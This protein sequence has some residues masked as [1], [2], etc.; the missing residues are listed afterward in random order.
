MKSVLC[1]LALLAFCGTSTAQSSV[2]IYGVV[3]MSIARLSGDG[4]G[5]KTGVAS[6]SLGASRLGFSGTEDLGGGLSAN[7]I[8]ESALSLDDGQSAGVTFVRQST[9]GLIGPFGELRLGRDY[10][11]T[12]LNTSRFDPFA[13]RGVGIG[14]AYNNFFSDEVRNSNTVGYFLPPNMGGF[15]G[16]VQYAFGE[17]QSNVP[18]TKQRDYTGGRLGYLNGPLNLAGAWG[19]YK[20]IVGASDTAPVVIGKDLTNTNFGISWDF[21]FIKPSFL[22][23]QEKVSNGAVGAS[24]VNSA[25]LGLFAIVGVGEI[26]ATIGHYDLKD[27]ANDWNKFSFG[28]AYN[29]SKRTA[30]YTEMASVQNK[31]AATKSINL[32]GLSAIGAAP[33]RKANGIEFGIRHIF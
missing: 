20:Q 4:V 21:G 17:K 12:Y 32:D 29:L 10:A 7:F 24:Q 27:S 23:G 11:P 22:Y 2:S 30:L 3:D 9:L 6:G 16:Q 8:M 25:V 18:N 26:R 15:Y 5:H 31:G 33:G 13:N 14:N 28:Y 1:P 19:R